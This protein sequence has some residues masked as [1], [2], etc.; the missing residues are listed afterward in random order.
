[1][2][3]RPVNISLINRRLYLPQLLLTLS[4]KD[5]N[6]NKSKDKNTDSG[7]LTRSLHI[8]DELPV[9]PEK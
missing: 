9:I 3:F 4:S 6:K 7:L 2:R 1:M 5:K 8:T